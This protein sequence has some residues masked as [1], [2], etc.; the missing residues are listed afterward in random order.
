MTLL[1]HAV[2]PEF[3]RSYGPLVFLSG[4]FA[5]SP[6]IDGGT[7]HLPV[8]I[9]RLA[10]LAALTAWILLS[11]GSGIITIK[12]NPL[13]LPVGVFT[14]W[15]ALSVFWSPYTAVSLQWL[16]SILAY[17]ALLF[18]VM[19][20]VKSVRQ[21]R[22]LVRVILVMGLFEAAVGIYQYLWLGSVRATGTFFNP[23]FFATYEVAVF[24]VAFSLL[25]FGQRRTEGGQKAGSLS[26]RWEK[27]VLW[28]TTGLIGLAFVLAQSRGALLALG[29][30]VSFVGLYRFG[31]S[32]L[33]FLLLSLLL[34]SFIP[35]PLQQRILTVGAGDPYAFTRLDI[36]KNSLQRVADH[37]WG[38]GMGVYKYTSFQYRFPIEN[39]IARY[40]KRAES[41]HNEYLQMGVE[42][43][44]AGVAIFLVGVGFLGREIRKTLTG[45]L[46]PW[47]RG[48]VIG[49]T[50]SILGMLVHAG[51]DSVFHEPALVMLNVIFV[52]LILVLK[53]LRGAERAA[54]WVIPF[55]YHP[56]RVALVG[57]LAFLLTFIMIRPVA[58]W[59]AFEKGER[60]IVDGKMEPALA[61]FQWA[62]LIDP[63]T[64]AY[65][66]AVALTEA[67]LFQRTGDVG[68]AN[69]AVSELKIGLELNPLDGRLANRVGS[70]YLLLAQRAGT[71]SERAA[72]INQAETHFELAVKL[73][74]YSPFNYLELGK[75]RREQGRL[76]EAEAWF[77]QATSFEPNFL[78]AR[79]QLAELLLKAGRKE[80][81][82]SEYEEIL[83]IKE[84]YKG[85][86]L[87][88]LERQFLEVEHEHLSRALAAEAAS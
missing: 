5:F 72:M 80:N 60:E 45:E 29:M 18:L 63:G 8:L 64:S 46:E 66:D 53:R 62:T 44:V 47:E 56:A 57:A 40:A 25:C 3:I 16:I 6:L 87:N 55:P 59:Y 68:W 84:R 88:T 54:V 21:V 85:R 37:P 71:E 76:E 86:A 42:L 79:V 32:F 69:R 10:I 81:A 43:G 31:K 17:A 34:V 36:W 1:H 11:M 61:S 58:A 9:I 24:S 52:G 19:Q 2:A 83:K 78:P 39:A 13:F 22:W 38:V 49:C 14:G 30:A 7:T 82:V 33:A 50:G 15:A 67:R 77:R 12:K 23:N 4:L 20:F 28:V 48:L 27:L 65:H 74:P 75:L 41:A 51:A 70:L 73:D 26:G 35:N